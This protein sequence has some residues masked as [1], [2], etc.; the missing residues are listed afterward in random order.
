[1]KKHTE[2]SRLA[3]KRKVLVGLI[4]KK[5]SLLIQI[6]MKRQSILGKLNHTLT[7]SSSSLK[8][9]VV[10]QAITLE[11]QKILVIV[12]VGMMIKSNKQRTLL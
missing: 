11:I 2:R 1:M 9:E 10:P 12:L 6:Q 5:F 8:M 3:D 4:K 7:S